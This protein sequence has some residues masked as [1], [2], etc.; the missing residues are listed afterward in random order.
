MGVDP[1]QKLSERYKATI[2]P[3]LFE[4]VAL[5]V[6]HVMGF[7]HPNMPIITA[8]QPDQIQPLVWGL[9]PFFVKDQLGA[10]KAGTPL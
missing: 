6:H 8:E 10:V 2:N 1:S 3:S 5:P 7:S 4:K 9:I